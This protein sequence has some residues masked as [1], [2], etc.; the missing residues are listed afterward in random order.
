M[1]R[2]ADVCL[3]NAC[4]LCTSVALFRSA[5]KPAVTDL[6]RLPVSPQASDANRKKRI[7]A[8]SGMHQLKESDFADG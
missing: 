7:A 8:P 2:N 3:E 6:A 5:I 1:R 4:N